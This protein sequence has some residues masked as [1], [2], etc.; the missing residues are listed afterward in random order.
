MLEVNLRAPIA[1]ARALTPGMVER[2]RGHLVFMSSLQGKAATPVA[3]V[4]CATKFGLRGFALALR[5]DLR[6]RRGRGLGRAAGLHPRRRVC[7]PTPEPSCPRGS[8]RAHRRTSR[9]RSSRRSSAIG[10][11]SRW[12]RSGLRLGTAV[13]SVAPALSAAVSRRLG[14]E[15]I[16]ARIVAGQRAEGIGGAARP[17]PRR[18]SLGTFASWTMPP[19]GA[20]SDSSCASTRSARATPP[21]RAI[22]PH[23]C[24]PPISSPCCSPG[25]CTTTSDRPTIPATTT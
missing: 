5:E 18:A 6:R 12:R 9:T 22:P 24:R 10:P 13:A 2:G 21:A 14:S 17:V 15:Q 3:S 16:A 23:R 11:R 8:A 25:T 19:S 7:S 20:S 4:Y 1:L